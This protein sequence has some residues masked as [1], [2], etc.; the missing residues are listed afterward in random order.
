MLSKP[1]PSS[2]LFV[3]SLIRLCLA[4]GVGLLGLEW[5]NK[6]LIYKSLDST[7]PIRVLRLDRDPK[8]LRVAYQFTHEGKDYET[9]DLLSKISFQDAEHFGSLKAPIQEALTTGFYADANPTQVWVHKD[10]PFQETLMI[11][12]GI[13]SSLLIKVLIQAKRP[14][15]VLFSQTLKHKP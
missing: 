1:F 5:V 15:N 11:L 9:E 4:I 2:L 6:F 7:C 13:A 12:L 10:F 8:G 14:L 3:L